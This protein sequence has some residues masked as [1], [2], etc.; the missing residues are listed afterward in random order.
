MDVKGESEKSFY[1]QNHRMVFDL[2]TY[3]QSFVIQLVFVC[4][5]IDDG[6][7]FQVNPPILTST[8]F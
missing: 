8:A 4:E 6:D 5:R 2:N 3:I 7:D 1:A